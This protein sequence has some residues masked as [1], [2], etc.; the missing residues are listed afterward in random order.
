[1]DDVQRGSIRGRQVVLVLQGG[2][3]LGAYQAGVLQGLHEAGV[4]P[5]WIVG[6]SIGA[7]NG[8]L[9]AGNPPDARMER[10]QAFW[11]RVSQQHLIDKSWSLAEF[12]TGI[13][14]LNTV[15]C[16]VP[17]F[18]GPNPFAALGLQAPIGVEHAAFYST[19]PLKQTL[20]ELV[21]FRHLAEQDMRLTVG[22]VNVCS[23]E[24]KY[25]D[26]RHMPLQLE[27]IMASGALPPAF[28]AVEI[29]GHPYW[30]G[31][32]YSNTPLEVVLD[33]NPR[34]D[35]LIFAVNV[36]QPRGNP[37]ESIWQALGRQKDIQYASR[38]NSHV[39]RQ[40]QIHRL[41]HVI[42]ELAA[43]L[44]QSA[45]ADPKVREMIAYGCR[46]TMHMISLLAPRLEGDDYTKDIDFDETRIRARWDAGYADAQRA[47]TQ[48][49]WSRDADP[50][51]GIVVHEDV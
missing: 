17:G 6:T 28:P 9:I 19:E 30:D 18:F 47:L 11:R 40:G 10:L 42:N 23:G 26:T 34:R 49:R 3:A 46:T 16:G 5:D 29:D 31:G 37:P 12:A 39:M 22:A 15:V 38:I 2:G 14:H 1:M 25:F 41:R 50:I 33:D 21:D 20:R 4:E 44:P 8:A 48:E 43:H 13:A 51:E 45:L 36:W 7:I 35:S 27:H 24:M 32:I